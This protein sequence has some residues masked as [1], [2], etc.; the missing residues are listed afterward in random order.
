MPVIV[1]LSDTHLDRSRAR[2]DR[3]VATL[4]Y[5]RGLPVVDALV[6]TGD[7][8]NDGLKG[9][10]G[11]LFATLPDDVPTLVVAGNHDITAPLST[12]LRAHGRDGNPNTLL[13][14]PGLTIIGL[15]SH[16]DG[17]DAGHLRADAVAFARAALNEH[18]GPAVLA[19]HHPPVTI[20]HT[21]MDRLRL[22]NPHDLARL[23]SDHPQVVA[24]LT[25]HVHSALVS[26]FAGV[27]LLGAP[28][29]ASALALDVDTALVTD[30]T[31]RPG[32][33]VHTIEGRHVRTLFHYVTM[34]GEPGHL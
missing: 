16:V 8:A 29:V 32:L 11:E 19:M 18:T 10:Y 24:V 14:V 13:R 3:L 25:G 2:L 21:A 9:E 17:A 34:P 15:D 28:G 23:V 5:V 12:A 4:S 26:E 22:S 33:A 31:A 27:P 20:G 6:V 1:H 30:P 7:L